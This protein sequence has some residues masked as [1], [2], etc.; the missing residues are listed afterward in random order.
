[1]KIDTGSD[2][3][4]VREGLLKFSRQQIFRDKSFNLRYPTGE[5]VPVKFK[6]E[7]LIEVGEL[8]MKLPVY[9]VDMKDDCLLGNDFLSAKKIEE[10]LISF[11]GVSSQE[12]KEFVCSRIESETSEVPFFLREL[13]IKE[14]QNLNEK[15]KERFANFLIGFQ[16]VFSEEIIAG[17]C[18]MVEHRIEIENSGPIKQVPRRIPFHLQKD[19]DKEIEEMKRQGV[20]EESN[21][22]WVSPAVIVKKKDGSIRFCVDFRKLNAITKKDSYPTGSADR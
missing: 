10:T 12:R 6:V 2:V 8:S 13:F 16:D 20:I 5:R 9:V 19:I 11:F 7:V 3:T 15:Q 21:S 14:T 22:P 4:L 18:G 17:N 1:M